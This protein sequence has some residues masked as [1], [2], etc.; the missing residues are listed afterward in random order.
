LPDAVENCVEAGTDGANVLATANQ[1][2]STN[3]DNA[4]AI[5]LEAARP[6]TDPITFSIVSGPT[7][8]SVGTIGTPTCS[9]FACSATV[10]YTPGSNYHGADS[11]T[12]K[13]SDGTSDSNT[14]TVSI[15]I[16]PINDNPDA[17]DDSPT[18]AEDSGANTINVRGNDNDV[19]GDTLTVTAVTQGTNG[20]VA[21]TN[22]GA[23]VSYTPNANFF[24]ADSFT[25]TVN[26]GNG[27]SDT[28]TVNVTV[29]NVNDAPVLTSSVAMSLISAT[30]S[31]LFNVG[32]AASA[33]DQEGETVTIQ[34]AV[35]GDEDDQTPT[36]NSVVHSPDAKDIAP[37]TLR[38]RG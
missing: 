38:L 5:T 23:D 22:G 11:F 6:D 14:S 15:T 31:N 10:T 18:I 12:F 34:V 27:G 28:A 37:N 4:V 7:N 26:D 19:D 16:S 2:T 36:L 35:F 17:I 20:S 21:I 3:E 29:T 24:G 32:L 30:N 33:T 1:S 13:V 9:N 25:Y 8:G